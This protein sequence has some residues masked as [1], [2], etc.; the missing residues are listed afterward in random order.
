MKS[1]LLFALACTVIASVVLLY[2]YATKNPPEIRSITQLKTWQFTE[3]TSEE[4]AAIVLPQA[5]ASWTTVESPH[6]FRLSDLPEKSAGFYRN[7]ISPEAT[8]QGQSYYLFL[9]GAGAVVDVFVNGEHV[10]QHKGAYTACWFD[11]TPK[12]HFGTENELILRITNRDLEATNCLSQSNL[13]YTNGGLYRSAWLVKTGG[14]HIYPDNGSYG[15]YLTPGHISEEQA[16]LGITAY[17]K[18]SLNDEAKALVRSHITGPDGKAVGTVEKEITLPAQANE[19]VELQQNIPCPILWDVHQGNLYTVRT[20]VIVNGETVDA[21]TEQTGIRTIVMKD[22][23]FILNGHKVLVRGVCKHH[24]DEHVWNAMS[25]EQLQWEMDGMMD[26]GVNTVRLAHYPH[27]R[28]EY[29]LTDQ[30]GLLVWAEN[31]LAGHRWDKGERAQRESKP[32]PVGEQITREMVRQNWNHPSIVF[33]SSGNETHDKTAHYYADVIRNEDSTRLVTY[34]SAGEKP[35][36]VDFVAGN[37]YQGWYWATYADFSELPT[38]EY[39]SETGAG[40]WT[41]HHVPYGT[42]QWSVDSFEPAEYTQMFSEYRF[43]TIF[44]NNPDGHKMFLWWNFREF[45]DHKFKNNRNTKGLLTLG[46]MPKDHYYLFQSFLRPEHPVLH[47]CDR[48]YFYRQID[49]A[50]GIKVYSNAQNVELFVNGASQGILNN[51]AYTLPGTAEVTPPNNDT[52]ERTAD[53]IVVDNVFFWKATLQPGKNVVEVRDNRNHT[54]SMV[55]YQKGDTMP[56]SEDSP[57]VDLQSSNPENPALY[58][59]RPIKAQGPIYYEVDGSSD[60]TFDSLPTELQGSSWIATKRL[61]DAA[62]HTNLTFT[63]GKA[64][65]IYVVYSTGS[66]PTSTLRNTDEQTAKEATALEADL[67]NAGFTDTGIAGIW[68]GH[69]LWLADNKVL[70]QKARRGD[71]ITIPAHTLDYVVLIKPE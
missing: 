57:V 6:C 60:N 13:F 50:N 28:F 71:Q 11:L 5:N 68:R 23:D 15:V 32:T 17:V 22:K 3:D 58:I 37:T 54:A 33:W 27:S 61:S 14:V 59:E 38:N 48:D 24:Q 63:I 35:D 29:R 31:G 30:N 40:A 20:E 25:N 1:R 51:G 10:G 69:D 45:F 55:I 16:E 41:T 43:Q 34:A 49:P 42:V 12:L 36:N 46:G 53:G 9:E 4:N 66:F 26:L 62:N 65:R 44:R 39:V 52:I 67:L 64:A 21:V 7:K 19:V 56:V 70:V 47:L 2:T 18:N 8:E